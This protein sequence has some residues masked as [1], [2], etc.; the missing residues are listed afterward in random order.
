MLTKLKEKKQI[1]IVE[2]LKEKKNDGKEN[3]SLN[4]FIFF[5]KKDNIFNIKSKLELKSNY[6]NNYHIDNYKN[7]YNDNSSIF[8]KITSKQLFI[9]KDFNIKYK[10]D[11]KN[12]YSLLSN[13]LI[14]H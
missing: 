3:N 9:E 5:N 10:N 11:N 14:D 13:K 2:N 8:N 6:S 1:I 4:Q 7:L 12:I